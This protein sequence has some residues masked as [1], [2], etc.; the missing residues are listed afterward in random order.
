MRTWR[1]SR[2]Q[3]TPDVAVLCATLVLLPP[4]HG[5]TMSTT[6]SSVFVSRGQAAGASSSRRP[7][8]AAAAAARQQ[9]RSFAPCPRQGAAPDACGRGD[10]RGNA[11]APPSRSRQAVP[12]RLSERACSAL[13]PPRPRRASQPLLSGCRRHSV[14]CCGGASCG[15][16]LDITSPRRR[17]RQSGPANAHR[18]PN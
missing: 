3:Q 2:Q 8:P 15:M 4:P 12:A 1:P 5:A 14:A 18:R 13:R 7:G 9:Q 6:Q 17:E 10:A 11:I 16:A